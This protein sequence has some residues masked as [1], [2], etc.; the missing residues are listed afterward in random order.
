MIAI[1]PE[2]G[3][4][5]T[6]HAGEQLGLPIIGTPLSDI[7]SIAWDL[8]DSEEYD[9][10]LIGSAN[11]VRHAGDQLAALRHLPVFAVGKKTADAAIEAGFAVEKT[12]EGGLQKLLDEL[13]E[14]PRKLLRLAGEDHVALAIPRHLNID[15]EIVYWVAHHPIPEQI[16]AELRDK[17]LVLLH[18]ANA[19]AHFAEECGRLQID[20]GNIRLAAIGPR[21][22]KAAGEGWASASAAEEPNDASLLALARYMCH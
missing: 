14:R 11:A 15:T 5:A 13:D 20:R 17:P 18:S 6:L 10:I 4:S 21:V 8:R 2:P 16:I 9:G 19:A 7:R 22:L 3:L 12:G 1:R